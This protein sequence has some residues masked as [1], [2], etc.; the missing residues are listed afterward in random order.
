MPK[1]TL[2]LHLSGGSCQPHLKQ[3]DRTCTVHK[4]AS[5]ANNIYINDATQNS[6][7]WRDEI[8]H[9]LMWLSLYSRIPLAAQQESVMYNTVCSCRASEYTSAIFENLKCS[10]RKMI[11]CALNNH[12]QGTGRSHAI[13]KESPLG[14]YCRQII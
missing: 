8:R 3:Q 1:M 11:R 12:K 14:V 13:C 6:F 2:S 7:V 5:I 10:S 9:P 4:G